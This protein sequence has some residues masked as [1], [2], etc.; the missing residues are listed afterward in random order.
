[1]KFLCIIIIFLGLLPISTVSQRAEAQIND[2]EARQRSVLAQPPVRH[3]PPLTTD[4]HEHLLRSWWGGRVWLTKHGIDIVPVYMAEAAGNVSGGLSHG[5][6]YTGRFWVDV[7]IDW[8][9]LAGIRG[10]KSHTLFVSNSGRNLSKDR[11][12]NDPYAVLHLYGRL[13]TFVKLQ[14]AYVTQDL[15]KGHLQI[16][17][18]RTNQAL[19][20]D[21]SPLY[22][23]F[24]SK[25]ICRVPRTLTGS[26][27]NGFHSTG[28]S[29]WGIYIRY[30][31]VT[32]FYMQ[33]GAFES[34]PLHGGASGFNW[35]FRQTDGVN[36][37]FEI[38]WQPGGSVGER[39]SHFALGGYYD[40]APVNDVYWDDLGT[41]RVLSGLPGRQ[42]HSHTAM[43]AQFDHMIKRN[44]PSNVGGLIIFG[45]FT[46]TDPHISAFKQQATIGFEDVGEIH[47]RPRDGFGVQ[48]TYAWVSD[49]T[50]SGQKL[51]HTR[52]GRYP[53][54]LYSIQSHEI[55]F[56]AQY[57]Y[58]VHHAVDLQPDFQYIVRPNSQAGIKNATVIG[59][60]ARVNF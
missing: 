58:H 40:N 60:R 53:S 26:N 4:D 43:W 55:I 15:M 50:R 52:F 11:L 23:M 32:P 10:L 31:P 49:E 9:K 30:R 16:G 36:L 44:T 19:F 57:S 45:N 48:I 1:M 18:G 51:L 28:R 42:S 41:A 59:G 56:E 54:G 22:C 37:P 5:S 20:F 8:S 7:E 27:P 46:R 38:G 33:V 35:S 29:N 13:G 21:S 34:T 14:F 24:L 2:I 3:R 6:A 17:A 47:G 39:S 25:A 12:N